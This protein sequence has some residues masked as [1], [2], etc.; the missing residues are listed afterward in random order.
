VARF[1]QHFAVEDDEG[2]Q[3]LCLTRGRALRPL[4][5]DRVGWERRDDGSI[6]TAV[7]E[8]SSCLTRIDSRGRCEPVAANVTQLVIVAAHEPPPDW[9]LIDRYLVAAELM[10]ARAVIVIN[11]CDLEP[12][13]PA[14]TALYREIGYH[15]ISTSAQRR[16]GLETLAAVMTGELSVLVGQSGVGK[17]S[18]TNSL[19][20]EH[21]REIGA[22]TGKGKQGRHTTTTASLLRLP[23]GGQLIDSPG[24]RSYAPYIP[25]SRRVATCFREFRQYADRCRFAD[26][27]H[28]AE[29]DCAVKAA[30]ACG[31]VSA[32]RYESYFKLRATLESLG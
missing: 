19:L 29:P 26:C 27:E 16:T 18:L 31:A 3:F 8:R 15:V 6:V 32:Q 22:L 17:S 23:G 7:H 10:P 28:R 20:G 21:A 12:N 11:K 14:S 9:F 2:G 5:G 24:V 30:V 4:V 1:R 25:D 13:E